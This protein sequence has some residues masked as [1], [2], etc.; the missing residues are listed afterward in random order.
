MKK[1]FSTLLVA[2]A[3]VGVGAFAQS[4]PIGSAG[5]SSTPVPAT[6]FD[7][8]ELYL[9]GDGT[10]FLAIEKTADGAKDSLV[11]VTL[12]T[13]LKT[14]LWT[15]KQTSTTALGDYYSFTNAATSKLLSL[16]SKSNGT[17]VSGKFA[18]FGWDPTTP[19]AL[20]HIKA[21]KTYTVTA[22]TTTTT[23]PVVDSLSLTESATAGILVQA[24]IPGW[25]ALTAAQLNEYNGSSF[26]WTVTGATS[27]T[28]AAQASL[29]SLVQQ[30]TA[31]GTINDDLDSADKTFYLKKIYSDDAAGKAAYLNVDT[32]YYP[33]VGTIIDSTAINGGLRLGLDTLTS[34]YAANNSDKNVEAFQFSIW[35][36][37]KDSVI[38]E[39]AHIPSISAANTGEFFS[40]LAVTPSTATEGV[41][42]VVA[43]D[44]T[45]TA[46]TA[47]PVSTATK[48]PSIK[49]GAGTKVELE[50]GAYFIYKKDKDSVYVANL[51]RTLAAGVQKTVP[52]GE[53]SELVAATQWSL[54]S[55]T[56]SP[57][58][59]NRESGLTF[60]NFTSGKTLYSGEAENEYY[61]AG[62][63]LIIVP[64]VTEGKYVGYKKFGATAEEESITKVALKFNT[65]L[66][67]DVFVYTND[68]ILIGENMDADDAEYFNIA[69][70]DTFAIGAD[71]LVRVAY[72]LYS[73][74]DTV[75][76]DADAKA[77]KLSDQGTNNRAFVFRATKEE[78]K[79][80]V[81]SVNV[82]PSASASNYGKLDSVQMTVSSSN[83]YV[84]R[85]SG[86]EL[87]NGLFS[88]EA[89][90]APE[91]AAIS[92]NGH[93]RIYSTQNTTLAISVANDST[94]VLKAETE[95]KAD[96]GFVKENFALYI[97]EYKAD[98]VKPLYYITTQQTLGLTEEEVADD[99]RFF[100]TA[101]PT[102]TSLDTAIVAIKAKRIGVA[103]DSLHVY[104][105]SAAKDT[106]KPADNYSTFAFRK[107]DVDGQY[108]VENAK[109]GKYLSQKNGILTL[110]TET[111]KALAFGVEAAESAVAN[112]AIE[113]AV[114]KVVAGEGTI[115]VY[116]AAGKTVVVSNILGQTVASTVAASDI[117]TIA[118]PK[119]IVVVSVAGEAAVKAIVK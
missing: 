76:Y 82:N 108:Y 11:Y 107:A 13:D 1:R 34:S 73:G 91:Y 42:S 45:N 48:Y 81:I 90:L 61:Y 100:L 84:T 116:N 15:I 10:N 62:D 111:D 106:V 72:Y 41:V 117:A 80:Q 57:L 78:G 88:F 66:A 71:S 74:A 65:T 9:V 77:Y 37:V 92:P 33:S 60:N 4:A 87:L 105:V 94:G 68:S 24:Y 17:I 28:A 49:F 75:V 50:E 56:D 119:G 115:T 31:V 18:E 27:T 89:P 51:A 109:T 30:F 52:A 46:L 40:N 99:V 67:D 79:Y 118:A 102:A 86:Y 103:S 63:T 25:T 8:A 83:A 64:V 97:D 55:T 95:L 23:T 104:N 35:T 12:P 114:V 2:F 21:G 113:A 112:D 29:A 85:V 96:E 43:F 93:Y 70:V 7:D 3:A 5:L 22:T 101:I 14:A 26:T 19:T 39:V 16:N 53:E 47:S 110:E 38:V 44:G 32:V 54:G 6:T 20:T 58:F 69:A 98:V 36:N 59:Y